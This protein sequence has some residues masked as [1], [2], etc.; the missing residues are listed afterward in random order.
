MAEPGVGTEKHCL[1]SDQGD[2]GLHGF[3]AQALLQR[4]FGFRQLRLGVDAEH[5]ILPGLDDD[6]L[7]SE[8]S[9]HRDG[10]GQIIFAFAIVIADALENCERGG[11]VECHQAGIAQVDRT[12]GRTGVE[13]FSNADEL[14]ALQQQAS[15]AGGIS[16]PKAQ[17]DHSGARNECRAHPDQRLRAK[18]RRIA[19]DDEHIVRAARNRLS[20]GK[21]C[22]R[23]TAALGLHE[24]FTAR[25]HSS[26]FGRNRFPVGANYHRGPAV[27]GR[28]HDLEHM[29]E[30]SLAADQRA[31]PWREPNACAYPPRREHDRQARAFTGHAAS[32]AAQTGHRRPHIRLRHVEKGANERYGTAIA[33]TA[34]CRLLA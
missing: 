26:R 19:K 9:R 11:A 18:Q 21:H 2:A 20:R 4:G 17:H 29:P 16:C 14:V 30:Q 23:G 27:T 34:A 6:R 33:A 31:A 32:S 3:P 25:R 8:S 28:A 22:M 24:D 1:G 13:L 10:I 7:L 12:L 5:F 15:I